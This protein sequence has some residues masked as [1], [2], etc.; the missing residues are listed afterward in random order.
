MLPEFFGSDSP[1]ATAGDF[2]ELGKRNLSCSIWV[3]K[4]MDDAV[5]A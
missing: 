3:R 2:Y 4:G 1:A 5:S